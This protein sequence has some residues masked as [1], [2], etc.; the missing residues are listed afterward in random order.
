M[1]NTVPDKYFENL[2]SN[3][4]DNIEHLED[5]IQINAPTL[6]KVSKKEIYL[7]PE[8]YFQSLR[9]SILKKT[10]KTRVIR[11]GIIRA[12]AAACIILLFYFSSSELFYGS[13]KNIAFAESEIL[14]FYL[15]NLDEIELNDLTDLSTIEQLNT[16]G[17]F[18]DFNADELES[19]LSDNID[20]LA[21]ENIIENN[22]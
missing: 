9:N 7:T 13:E 5:E 12:A 11:M 10:N 18:E 17:L 4:L 19:Y 21:I 20:D 1:S 3:I 8:S 22:I 15:E 2:S 6:N 14:D 16:T